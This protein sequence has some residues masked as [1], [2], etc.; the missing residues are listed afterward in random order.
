MPKTYEKKADMSTVNRISEDLTAYIDSIKED[1][2]YEE[3]DKN[4]EKDVIIEQLIQYYTNNPMDDTMSYDDWVNDFIDRNNLRE[5]RYKPQ[6]KDYLRNIVMIIYANISEVDYDEEKETDNSE[7]NTKYVFSEYV[8]LTENVFSYRFSKI[9]NGAIQH[10][11]TNVPVSLGKTFKNRDLLLERAKERI[12]AVSYIYLE[13]T[14]C[15]IGKRTFAMEL[16]NEINSHYNNAAWIRYD[17]NLEQSILDSLVIYPATEDVETRFA[18][19]VAFLKTKKRKFLIFIDNTHSPE[20]TEDDFKFLRQF[21]ADIV[22]LQEPGLSTVE[23]F[24]VSSFSIEQ[25]IDVFYEYYTLDKARKFI[26]TI[27]EFVEI[28]DR[29]TFVIKLLAK[30]AKGYNLAEFFHRIRND[31]FVYNN[32][33]NLDP[34]SVTTLISRNLIKLMKSSNITENQYNILKHFA[35]MPDMYIPNDI[36][37]GLEFEST[38]IET[39]VN[40][41]LIDRFEKSDESVIYYMHPLMRSAIHMQFDITPKDC[42]SLITFIINGSYIKD[43]DNYSTF[44]VKLMIANGVLSVFEKQRFDEKGELFNAVA[45]WFYYSGNYERALK[46]FKKAANIREKIPVENHPATAIVCDNTARAY[47][48]V[49]NYNEAIEYGEK[50]L[51]IYEKYGDSYNNN[52][53]SICITIGDAYND[54]AEYETAL[55][56]YNKALEIVQKVTKI[57]PTIQLAEIYS[58]LGAVHNEMREPDTAIDYHMKA[59]KIRE[60][61]FGT[62]SPIT[63][64]TYN[65]LALIYKEQGDYDKSLDFNNKTLKIRERVLG[66]E[67]PL[68]AR[69]YNHLGRIYL[70]KGEYNKALDYYVKAYKIMKHIYGDAHPRTRLVKENLEATYRR[71]FEKWLN[72]QMK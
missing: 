61:L 56:Y 7:K 2:A 50:A 57:T 5:N 22:F 11:L 13:S 26:D 34:N 18:Q 20:V 21:N 55:S 52:I 27:E 43:E 15:G 9:Q 24:H 59:M 6:I 17:G 71:S 29:N 72:D 37:T 30:A 12:S 16:Y 32:L 60:K 53:S 38:D 44:I 64:L 10:H 25:G 48:A 14:L 47:N 4:V 66:V 69:T 45:C 1:I 58:K 46:L 62:D 40:L 28:A 42:R 41:G 49:G 23:A 39:I 19:I 68:T 35:V 54:N 31:G 8:N 70:N 67:H 33:A 3:L 51:A 36:V 65:S 63:A